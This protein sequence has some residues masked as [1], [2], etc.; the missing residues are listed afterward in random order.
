MAELYFFTIFGC[1]V[2]AM[3]LKYKTTNYKIMKRLFLPLLCLLL[4]ACGDKNTPSGPNWGE[5]PPYE[6][7]K[8]EKPEKPE[9][10]KD[11]NKPD[12]GG[13]NEGGSGDQ[14][15]ERYIVPTTEVAP[16]G[17]NSLGLRYEPGISINIATKNFSTRLSDIAAAGFKYIEITIKHE[18]GLMN[19]SDDEVRDIFAERQAAVD[20]A[21][22]KLWSIHL[23]YEDATW[24]NIGGSESIRKQSV[25]NIMRVLRLC[26]EKFPEC[27]NFVLHASKGTLSPRSKSVEQARK[28]LQEMI[29]VATSLGV[30][31]CV[32]NLVGSLCPTPSELTAT[33]NG[34]DNA[35]VTYDI[36]HANC[37]GEDVINFLEK[38][39]P[40]LGTVH[41]HD[42]IFGSRK[43]DHRM[44][45]EG[46][47]DRWDEVYNAM[48]N[49]NGYRGVFLFELSGAN[50]TQLMNKYK[51]IVESYKKR[52]EAK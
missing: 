16:S 44:I 12:E 23:P 45:G 52:Y 37:V 39:G 13:N 4:L 9:E 43:D 38:I 14:F 25:E 34:I 15:T 26:T 35:W 3:C 19:K 32:E 8:P 1:F 40:R 11:E 28:S 47:V 51:E 24:T 27:K 36:G 17:E 48:L 30:R 50:T 49:T 42:T 46:N 2:A 6:D 22:L 10:P 18:F 33:I 21:G 20:N 29:P 5:I 31:L 7:E 41:I